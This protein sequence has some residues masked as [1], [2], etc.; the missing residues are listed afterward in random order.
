MLSSNI[1]KR[2]AKGE[3]EKTTADRDDSSSAF[4]VVMSYLES[5]Q[6]DEPHRQA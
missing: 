1:N 3:Q 5:R 2:P 4:D 6:G